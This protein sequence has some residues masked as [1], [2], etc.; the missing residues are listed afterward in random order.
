MTRADLGRPGQVWQ[1][2]ARRVLDA[3][4]GLALPLTSGRFWLVQL[5]VLLV[6]FLD[7]VILDV[8]RL[9]PPFEIPRSTVSALL[10]IPVIY[11]ALNFGV[12]SSPV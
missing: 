10:L 5:G 9:Q 6:A 8:M 2:P 3:A 7:E 12:S 4:S 11:A 1:G